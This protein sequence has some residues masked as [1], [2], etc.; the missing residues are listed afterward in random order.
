MMSEASLREVMRTFPQGVVVVT[1]P[2]P[3]NGDGPRGITVSS[4]TSVSLEPPTILISIM[5]TSQAHDLID[6][7]QFLINILSDRQDDVSNRFA[8]P[9]LSSD[10]QFAGFRLSDRFGHSASPAIDGCLAYLQCRVVERLTVS[11]HTLF[12]GQVEQA[13]LGTEGDPLVYCARQYR[14]LGAPIDKS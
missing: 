6:S 1:T 2:P 5:K 13:Q 9:G 14:Q 12:V 3:A 4:F 10:E 11:D 7:G 8:T